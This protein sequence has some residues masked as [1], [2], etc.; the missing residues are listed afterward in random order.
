MH[1]ICVQITF[2][3]LGRHS[4]IC[5]LYS[6]LIAD[7]LQPGK[8]FAAQ[9]D[10][11][12]KN[13]AHRAQQGMI[14]GVS[15]DTKGSR[16]YLPIARVDVT[17]Q[18]NLKRACPEEVSPGGASGD[19]DESTGRAAGAAEAAGFGGAGHKNVQTR[20]DKKRVEKKAWQRE[21][22]VTRSVAREGAKK[23]DE[24]AEQKKP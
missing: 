15:E 6:K 13:F 22:H 11:R 12:I 9:G 17:T 20:T 16:V 24:S 23:A 10:P 14:V 8:R 5:G 18:H 7:K 21:K 19:K 3:L 1:D 4:T 2:K